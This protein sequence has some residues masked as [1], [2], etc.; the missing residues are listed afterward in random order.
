MNRR[1]FTLIELL[2][3]I[4]IIAILAAILFPVFAAAREKARQTTCASNERQIGLAIV[5][6]VQDYDEQFPSPYSGSWDLSGS[7]PSTGTYWTT[8]VAPYLKSTGVL[9]CPSVSGA[10]VA[11]PSQYTV[12]YQMNAYLA[13][14]NSMFTPTLDGYYPQNGCNGAPCTGQTPN[15]S[16]VASPTSTIMVVEDADGAAP[17]AGGWV[18]YLGPGFSPCG[19]G[20]TEVESTTDYDAEIYP[21]YQYNFVKIHSGGENLLFTDSH[22]KWYPATKLMG[23]GNGTE[24]FGGYV[25]CAWTDAPNNGDVDIMLQ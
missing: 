4:A 11:N 21:L 5:Q 25:N 24:S 18:S 7:Q 19:F 9:L 13:V 8:S 6:Y 16:E 22:V 1:G 2:V 14:P 3:V 23:L 10:Q 12:T 15:L 20:S 17:T